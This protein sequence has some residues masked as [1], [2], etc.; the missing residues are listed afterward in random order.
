MLKPKVCKLLNLPYISLA[1]DNDFRNEK[2]K[3]K[4]A[5]MGGASTPEPDAGDGEDEPYPTTHPDEEQEQT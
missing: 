2:N 4:T 5:A 3:A 1:G